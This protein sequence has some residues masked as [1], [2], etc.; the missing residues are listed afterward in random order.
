MCTNSTLN[1]AECLQE[2]NV[3]RKANKWSPA[4]LHVSPTFIRTRAAPVRRLWQQRG[5]DRE[6][7]INGL[8]QE[9]LEQPVC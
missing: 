8:N 2:L 6:L 4:C 3:V 9:D 7:F 5:T 1:Q